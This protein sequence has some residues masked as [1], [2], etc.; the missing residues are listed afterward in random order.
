M[1]AS[2]T[3]E[4]V[5]LSMPIRRRLVNRGPRAVRT[6]GDWILRNSGGTGH[7]VLIE[8]KLVPDY[9]AL[10]LRSVGVM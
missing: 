9:E 7:R 8:R 5:R 4:T 6:C 1:P 10:P 3:A 2:P